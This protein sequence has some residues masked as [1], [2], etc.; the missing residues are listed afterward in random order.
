MT[1]TRWDELERGR[2][3]E[4]HLKKRTMKNEEKKREET[5]KMECRQ[6]QL[7]DSNRWREMVSKR[8]AI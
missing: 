7:E 5:E 2:T 8:R 4:R 3:I 6:V 1:H